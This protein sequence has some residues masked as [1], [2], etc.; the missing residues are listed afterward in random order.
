MTDP[1]AAAQL[2]QIRILRLPKTGFIAAVAAQGIHP[3]RF[4]R[5]MFANQ[6]E[7]HLI[8]VRPM[9]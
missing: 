1:P 9:V 7:Y 2:F 4:A 3:Q 6:L 5:L 8:Q